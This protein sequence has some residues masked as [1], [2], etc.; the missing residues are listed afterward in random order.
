MWWFQISKRQKELNQELGSYLDERKGGSQSFFKS[1]ESLIPKFSSSDNVPEVSEV[2]ATVVEDGAPKKKSFFWFLFSKAKNKEY[3]EEDL[4]EIEHV[5]EE[6]QHIEEQEGEL[7]E[8]YEDL[9]EKRESLLQRL[10]FFLSG[11]KRV[12]EEF[13]EEED[14]EQDDDAT[15]IREQETRATL[16]IIHKW[17]GRLPPEQIDAFKRS[18]D[19]QKYKDLL[20]MYNLIK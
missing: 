17:I 15:S 7:Q 2:G 13:D 14:F 6:I 11:K 1:I 5:E 16:K 18:P 19:F 12:E 3:D 9:E 10:F 4:E 8:E 20:E